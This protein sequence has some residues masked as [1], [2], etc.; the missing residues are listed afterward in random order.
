MKLVLSDNLV[1]ILRIDRGEEVFSILKQFVQSEKIVS[2]SFFGIGAALEIELG[3]YNGHLRDY[4]KKPFFE[5]LEIVSLIG[6]ISTLEGQTAIH[7]HGMFGRTDFTTIG[8]H[9]FKI[10]I[11]ATCELTIFKHN[12]PMTRQLDSDIN[13]NLLN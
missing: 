7:A 8:G 6:N 11:N 4:R 1:C 2:G 13:I 3:Y 12:L 10:V 5:D 9:I